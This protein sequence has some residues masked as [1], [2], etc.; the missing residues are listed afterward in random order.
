MYTHIYV[1]LYMYF[2][3]TY[4]PRL[5]QGPTVMDP[6]F[7]S[8]HDSSISSPSPEPDSEE[9][10]FTLLFQECDTDGSGFVEVESLVS[11]IRKTQ[12]GQQHHSDKEEVYDSQ[13]D[14]CYQL[15]TW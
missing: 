10:I 5:S 11:F 8:D 6:L 14:V 3:C 12:L 7:E 2:T 13:E 9:A 15:F 4:S 1:Y